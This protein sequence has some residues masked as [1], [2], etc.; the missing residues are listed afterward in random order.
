MRAK[1]SA[2]LK[3]RPA[4]NKGKPATEQ[5][6][7]NMSE[8]HKLRYAEGRGHSEEAIEKMRAA[9]IGNTRT[10]G[11]KLT[12]EHIEKIASTHRGRKRS[13]EARANMAEA[14]RKRWARAREQE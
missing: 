7:A 5:A 14:Q 9:A 2:T 11:A 12:S 3:G 1:V 10:K 6:R 4:N 8:A 13:P